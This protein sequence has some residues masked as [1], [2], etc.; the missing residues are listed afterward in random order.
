MAAGI[1]LAVGGI[2][3]AV[4][5]PI[6]VSASQMIASTNAGATAAD[7]ETFNIAVPNNDENML[8][9]VTNGTGATITA[10]MLKGDMWASTSDSTPVSILTGKTYAM[11]ID[12]G[13]Y[14]QDDG[15]IKVVLTNSG[16]VALNA[17][18]KA[19]VTALFI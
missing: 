11:T 6:D 8:I 14:K 5:T 2:K 7:T 4:N 10:K 18:A 13:K 12:S 15:T 9:L 3:V 17:S 16:T 19:T 1:G